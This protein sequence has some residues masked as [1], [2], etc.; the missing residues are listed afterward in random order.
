MTPQRIGER[1]EVMSPQS[2]QV[3]GL[4]V[5]SGRKGGHDQALRGRHYGKVRCKKTTKLGK[6]LVSIDT[7][8][9]IQGSTS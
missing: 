8:G 7:L 9:T 5:E 1:F 2:T 6:Y 3:L 4:R